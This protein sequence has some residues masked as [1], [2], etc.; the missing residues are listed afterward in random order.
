MIFNDRRF[1]ILVFLGVFISGTAIA[2]RKF[3]QPSVSGEMSANGL[4]ETAGRRER[5][6]NQPPATNVL[7][8][9]TPADRPKSARREFTVYRNDEGE[10]VCRE[11]TAE[12][13]KA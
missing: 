1:V 10:I 2:S 12:E 8:A 4:L 9:Q 6:R 13:I 11:A 3:S 5:T 7:V